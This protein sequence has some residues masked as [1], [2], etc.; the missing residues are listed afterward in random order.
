MELPPVQLVNTSSRDVCLIYLGAA[1]FYKNANTGYLLLPFVRRNGKVNSIAT[2][3]Q[4]KPAVIG[5]AQKI[6]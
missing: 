5:L 6:S 4:M 3:G 1:Q 2:D